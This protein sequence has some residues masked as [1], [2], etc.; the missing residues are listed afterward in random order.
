[1]QSYVGLTPE[2]EVTLRSLWPLLEPHAD[3]VVDHFYERVQAFESTRALLSDDAQVQRLKGSLRVW[4]EDTVRSDRDAAYVQR[5]RRIGQ[6]HADVGLQPQFLHTAMAVVLADLHQLIMTRCSFEEAGRI[7]DVATRA[8]L[9]DL[10]IMNAAYVLSRDRLRAQELQRLLVA[11]LALAVLVV[12]GQGTVIACTPATSSWLDGRDP[13]GD[14]WVHALPAQGEASTLL[15]ES[16]RAVSEG[17][18]VVIPRVRSGE[19]TFRITFVPLQH[20]DAS[21]L[22]QIE[23][24][25]EILSLEARLR[26]AESLARIGAMSAAVANELGNPLAA[27]RATMQVIA[28]GLTEDPELVGVMGK[29]QAE[30]DRMS[31]LV[32]SLKAYAW[33]EPPAR[34]P[35]DLLEA[36]RG[37][38]LEWSGAVEPSVR[39]RGAARGDVSHVAVILQGLLRN[40]LQAGAVTILIELWDGRMLVSDDGPGVDEGQRHAIFDAFVTTK[41]KGVGLGLT[42]ARASAED[43]GGSL[44]LATS[45]LG[46]AAFELRLPV[47]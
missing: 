2:D 33:R 34:R 16:Q 18:V 42:L 17:E 43:M 7:C 14:A 32:E 26:E 28:D 11:H 45:S 31:R 30:V 22:I 40:S 4:L 38:L 19:R 8:F 39:G 41:P 35:I 44:D 25:T 9:I 24:L 6:V 10:A 21:V 1:M 36:V 29:V 46:G 37:T 3:A 13:T 5:R 15:A 20:D 27:I 23:E 47:V 12:D